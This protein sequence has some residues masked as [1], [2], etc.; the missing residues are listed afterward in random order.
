M[1]ACSALVQVSAVNPNESIKLEF[2]EHF[3]GARGFIQG[4]KRGFYKSESLEV[5]PECFGAES[6]EMAFMIY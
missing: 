5:R 3:Q 1:A 6:Q 4:F 2:E